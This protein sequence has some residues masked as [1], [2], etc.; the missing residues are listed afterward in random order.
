MV[1]VIVCAGCLHSHQ[2]Q[3]WAISEVWAVSNFC[4]NKYTK[5]PELTLPLFRCSTHGSSDELKNS[6]LEL[7]E[8]L[9]NCISQYDQQGRKR[10]LITIFVPFMSG[11]FL[12]GNFL[13]GNF[14]EGNFLE[15]NFLEGNLIGNI[16]SP[17]VGLGRRLLLYWGP[18]LQYTTANS[19]TK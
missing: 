13:E 10:E 8:P 4:P 14:L 9:S 6:R 12:E 7:N 2:W 11:N 15:G 5:E 1:C 19:I 3:E 16:A 18:L 17:L